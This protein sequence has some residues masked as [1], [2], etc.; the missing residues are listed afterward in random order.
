MMAN[1]KHYL[2]NTVQQWKYQYQTGP[3]SEGGT[4]TW[5]KD[6]TLIMQDIA[7]R[8]STQLELIVHIHLHTWQGTPGNAQ[9]TRL[10]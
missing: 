9:D 1:I 6:N 7:R 8:P 5:N 2:L 4:A 3:I 10:V